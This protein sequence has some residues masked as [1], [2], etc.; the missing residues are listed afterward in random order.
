MC[1]DNN[2]YCGTCHACRL[3]AGRAHPN[4]LWVEPEKEG[5]TIK[6]D[7]IRE[8]SEFV[9]QSSLQG[10]HRIV[11]INPANAMNMHAANA[12]LKT[13]EEPSSGAIIFICHRSTGELACDYSQSLSANSFSASAISTGTS[14]VSTAIERDG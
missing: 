12:L 6:V 10:V 1:S 11:L 8:V 2:Y 13:L 14:V 3:I 7:Q 4:V 5:Q 9:N